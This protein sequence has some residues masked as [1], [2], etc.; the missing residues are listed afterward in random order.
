[1]NNGPQISRLPKQKRTAQIKPE[2]A[3]RW[4]KMNSPLGPLFIAVSD[5]GV[6]A[7]EFGAAKPKFTKLPKTA[8]RLEENSR[9]VA[10]IEA[11]LREYF[12]GQ[13]SQFDIALDTS[14]LTSFQRK[15]LEITRLIP[16]GHAWTYRDL[17]QR[18]GN[19]NAARPVGQA[20]A[21]NPIAIII[22]CHRVIASD[23][24]LGG[25]SGGSG[26]AAKRWL[27]RHEGVPS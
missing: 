12:V 24:S 17:A 26:L 16:P 10:P 6:C 23:K 20:L 27:L 18:M 4:G 9:A 3:V 21:R 5:R 13:R 11:Q 7:L 15:V 25:Y 14:A 2:L 19:P 22:P 8:A 1:M